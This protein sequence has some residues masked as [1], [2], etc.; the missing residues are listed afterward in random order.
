MAIVKRR[1]DVTFFLV[2]PL[3]VGLKVGRSR[4][5]GYPTKTCPKPH[6]PL[7]ET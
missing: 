6:L 7:S 1:V 2:A 3:K 4:Q 5:Q